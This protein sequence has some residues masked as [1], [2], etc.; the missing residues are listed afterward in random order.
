MTLLCST[1][2]RVQAY[3]HAYLRWVLVDSIAPQ[4]EAF[5]RGFHNVA[6]GPALDLFRAEELQLLVVGS[7]ELDFHALERVAEYEAPYSAAHAT[8]KHFWEVVHEL[9]AEQKRKFLKFSTGSDRAPIRGLGN[10]RFIVDRAGPD[11]DRL[12]S[13]STC[14]QFVHL[15]EYATKEKLEA[16]LKLSIE[17]CEGF[18]VI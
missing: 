13:A 1:P 18:G 6:G 14:F 4:F 9:S 15:P 5:A 3:V 11:S 16:K 10:M 12:V 17:H 2:S 7:Q 8:I